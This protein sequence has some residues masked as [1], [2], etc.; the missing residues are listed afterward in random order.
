M[1][2]L[3]MELIQGIFSKIT[4]LPASKLGRERMCRFK[5]DLDMSR[6][7]YILAAV[8]R[9]WRAISIQ[10]PNL[11]TFIQLVRNPSGLDLIRQN[12]VR[13][14]SQPLDLSFDSISNSDDICRTALH[15]VKS[16]A[17]RLR[18]AQFD[19]SGS[20]LL[21]DVVAICTYCSMPFLEDLIIE[22][23][24]IA[25]ELT[26]ATGSYQSAQSY[27]LPDCPML[28]HFTNHLIMA[29]PTE[30]LHSL[31]Y[32]SLS[33]RDIVRNLDERPFWETLAKAPALEYL[34]IYFPEDFRR[35]RSVEPPQQVSLLA[36]T[37]LG[38]YGI[39]TQDAEVWTSRLCMPR[40]EHLTISIESCEHL[41]NIFKEIRRRQPH[42]EITTADWMVFA[43]LTER[44]AIALVTNLE[45]VGTLELSELNSYSLGD[46]SFFEILSERALDDRSSWPARF[47]RLVIRNCAFRIR[48]CRSFASFAE[49]RASAAKEHG[50]VPLK[51]EW[52]ESAL[53]SS[54]K[55]LESDWFDPTADYF[56]G[57]KAR[58][59][60]YR[61]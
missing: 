58:D 55:D 27:R 24:A 16:H 51:V 44:D 52:I 50:A 28:E 42:I 46:Q 60:G 53:W 6:A 12:L 25:Y 61:N 20:R 18:R 39:L 56:A 47:P 22:R 4:A 31:K 17:H 54:K 32:L 30:T 57:I 49:I 2:R 10:T 21:P 41:G 5:T 37:H 23:G 40:L 45:D 38:V 9:H 26:D 11:W 59:G 48:S 43:S 33:L 14:S 3:P 1:D 36:L 19:F 8:S 13:S 35:V 7:P 29:V 15:L 34:D